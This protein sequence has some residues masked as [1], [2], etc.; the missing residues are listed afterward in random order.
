MRV[1][2]T[3]FDDS[4]CSGD[5]SVHVTSNIAIPYTD[6]FNFFFF[7]VKFVSHENLIIGDWFLLRYFKTWRIA[8]EGSTCFPYT[9]CLKGFILLIIWNCRNRFKI[10]IFRVWWRVSDA[11]GRSISRICTS[12][13]TFLYHF[14]MFQTRACC[15][16]FYLQNPWL[17]TGFL[18][19]FPW[20]MFPV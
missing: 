8:W 18:L 9:D 11:S 7:W 6:C 12:T 19:I 17:V 5:R 3:Q 16:I 14:M 10:V 4:K 15:R 2:W 1:R 13:L 20:N